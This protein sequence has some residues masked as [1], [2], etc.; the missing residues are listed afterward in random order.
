VVGAQVRSNALG[1]IRLIYRHLHEK[2]IVK[3]FTG[4]VLC[5]CIK[6]T[7]VDESIPP[8]RK[9]PSGDVGNHAQLHGVCKLALKLL[10]DLRFRAIHRR[11]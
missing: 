8:E 2:P 10:H 1:V 6:A 3:V 11:T 5:D 4:R 9:A 7:T